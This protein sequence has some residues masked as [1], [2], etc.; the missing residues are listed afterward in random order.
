M[1]GKNLRGLTGEKRRE[2]MPAISWRIVDLPYLFRRGSSMKSLALIVTSLLTTAILL[3]ADKTDD[4]AARLEK[5][6]A[7]LK[8]ADVEVRRKTLGSLNHSDLSDSLLK[9]MLEM[10]KDTDGE[11]RSMAATAVGTHGEA[12]LPAVPILIAQLK[13]DSHKE[14]RE[15]AARAAGPH[16][17]GG[18]IQSRCGRAVATGCRERYRPGHACGRPR[19][20]RDDGERRPRPD[21]GHPKIPAP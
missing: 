19:G 11:V 15:T 5:A 21:H 17:Q 18:E 14:A 12:A 1:P 10:F 13:G 9:D 20:P 7:G 6:R 3:A 8:S 16:R 2:R 4:K